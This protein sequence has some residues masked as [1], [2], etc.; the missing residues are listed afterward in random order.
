MIDSA[1]PYRVTFIDQGISTDSMHADFYLDVDQQ[2]HVLLGA[3]GI[4]L[5]IDAHQGWWYPDAQDVK[6]IR[7]LC[8]VQ[9]YELPDCRTT[10]GDAKKLE[11][12]ESMG[13]SS[14]RTLYDW[15]HVGEHYIYEWLAERPPPSDLSHLSPP[16]SPPISSIDEDVEMNNHTVGIIPIVG[17]GLAPTSELAHQ[18]GTVAEAIAN[19][20]RSLNDDVARPL[21]I[22]VG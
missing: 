2:R 4:P 22:L 8:H 9:E 15:F 5:T 12:A 18:D 20:A 21:N 6:R 16:R 17:P 7:V 3:Y 19:T 10:I 14:T 1:Y 11:R 13:T